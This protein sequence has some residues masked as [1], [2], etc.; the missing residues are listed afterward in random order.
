L[1]F[2]GFSSTNTHRFLG[3]AGWKCNNFL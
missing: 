2:D 1:T 3:T